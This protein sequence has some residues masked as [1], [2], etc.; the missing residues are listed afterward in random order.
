VRG[1]NLQ[2]QLSNRKHARVG[3]ETYGEWQ[4]LDAFG[5]N[6]GQK[7]GSEQQGERERVH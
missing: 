5:E 2:L 7:L 3:E 6:M 1:K 4:D